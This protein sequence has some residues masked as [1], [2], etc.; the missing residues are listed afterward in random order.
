M[1][2]HHLLFSWA[3][4][5]QG[6]TVTRQGTC[7]IALWCDVTCS[8][9][10]HTDNFFFQLLVKKLTSSMEEEGGRW[11]EKISPSTLMGGIQVCFQS[12]FGEQ[13]ICHGRSAGFGC[14]L[15]PRRTAASFCHDPALVQP[16]CV[17]GLLRGAGCGCCDAVGSGAGSGAEL[18]QWGTV[19]AFAEAEAFP[20]W[21]KW[22]ALIRNKTH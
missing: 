9:F 11:E 13:H 19:G 18:A 16:H 6:G 10:E 17:S 20:V 3:G 4:T 8:L 14:D 22:R 15:A 5:E 2:A 7:P 1:E 12:G 21:R